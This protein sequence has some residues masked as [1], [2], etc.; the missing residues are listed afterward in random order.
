MYN[1]A[2]QSESPILHVI[3]F[4]KLSRRGAFRDFFPRER[5]MLLNSMVAAPPKGR[6]G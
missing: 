3:R 6:A 5:V 4:N 1:E 2:E